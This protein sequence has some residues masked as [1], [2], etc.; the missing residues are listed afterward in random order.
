MRVRSAS[1]SID[2][3]RLGGD[4]RGGPSSW[5]H[6][7]D[8]SWVQTAIWAAAAF[9]GLVVVLRLA[10]PRS[11]PFGLLLFGMVIG[12]INALIAVGLILIYRTN[13]IINFALAEI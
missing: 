5:R 6:P 9:L 1:A 12:S 4:Q 8:R 7:L 11:V 2:W 13:R 10:L 3:G